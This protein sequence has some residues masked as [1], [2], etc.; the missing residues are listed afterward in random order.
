MSIK[1]QPILNG[2]ARVMITKPSL[3]RVLIN[4]TKTNAVTIAHVNT[5]RCHL[6][7]PTLLFVVDQESQLNRQHGLGLSS[8]CHYSCYDFAGYLEKIVDEL[9]RFAD[10]FHYGYSTEVG[11]STLLQS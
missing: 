9:E 6:P 8:N 3:Y 5:R 11:I 7:S 2:R 1:E 4:T 10:G